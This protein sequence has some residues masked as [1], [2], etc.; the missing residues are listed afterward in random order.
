[1]PRARRR[2]P[3]PPAHRPSRRDELAFSPPCTGV[4]LETIRVTDPAARVLHIGRCAEAGIRASGG[5][6]ARRR[7][8]DASAWRHHH[9]CRGQGDVR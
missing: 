3:K 2:S 5:G 6:D 1:M 7:H 8:V 9:R 4:T